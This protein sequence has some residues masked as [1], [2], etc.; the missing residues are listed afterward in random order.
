MENGLI[1]VEKSPLRGMK[2]EKESPTSCAWV[3]LI[4]PTM[5]IKNKVFFIVY[6]DRA[7]YYLTANRL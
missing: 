7:S 4:E 5:Q 1:G 6:I 2:Y 3:A